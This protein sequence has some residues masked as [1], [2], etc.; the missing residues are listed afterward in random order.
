MSFHDDDSDVSRLN[1]EAASGLV[2]VH[3]WTFAVLATAVD[4]NRRSDGVFDVAVAPVLQALGLLPHGD[5][6]PVGP[7]GLGERIFIL[8]DGQVGFRDAGVRIDLGGIAK[9]YAVDRAVEVLR[10]CGITQGIVNAGGD[11]AVFGP[12]ARNDPRPRSPRS[13]PR[14]VPRRGSRTPRW[15]RAAAGSIRRQPLRRPRVR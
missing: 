3:P 15:R 1:R 5:A 2:T 7:A 8:S 13:H 9:G 4:L 10:S 12:I 6:V 11:L 14:D